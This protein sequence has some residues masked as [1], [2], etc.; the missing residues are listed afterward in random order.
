MAS[1]V[2]QEGIELLNYASYSTAVWLDRI[3]VI[4]SVPGAAEQ[5]PHQT[6]DLWGTERGTVI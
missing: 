1:G 4:L 2:L 3:L 6:I 5:M